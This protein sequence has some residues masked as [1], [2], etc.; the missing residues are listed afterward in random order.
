MHD[1]SC[2]ITLTYN[3]ENLPEHN[4]LNYEHLQ[5]FWKRLRKQRGKLRYYACG[6]YGDETLR[7][8]YHAIIFGHA[9]TADRKIIRRHPTLLWTSPTLES[10]WGLGNVSVG[11]LT[12]QTAQ[13]TASYVTKKLNN[14]KQYVRIDEESGELIPLV[15]PRAFVSL[16]PAIASEWLKHHGHNVYSHDHV[17]IDGRPQKPP[18]YYDKWLAKQSNVIT[19]IIKDRRIKNVN[20]TTPEQNHAHARNAHA[21]AKLNNKTV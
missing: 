11:A 10:A 4:S 13:Y 19:Q 9:F 6:E 14:K 7:P 18:K 1:E 5:K 20:K 17:V 16:R 3:D 12:F 8:H 21:R 15:Q 2:F